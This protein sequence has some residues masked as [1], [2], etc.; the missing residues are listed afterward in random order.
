ML[1]K[2]TWSSQVPMRELQ[3][4]SPPEK[5]AVPC[6]P[7]KGLTVGE[8]GVAYLL[9]DEFQKVSMGMEMRREMEGNLLWTLKKNRAILCRFELL[10]SSGFTFVYNVMFISPNP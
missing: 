4:A 2:Y 6:S 10:L 8:E 3:C 9:P 1:Y 5:A 7:F